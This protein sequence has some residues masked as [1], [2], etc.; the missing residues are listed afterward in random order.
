[1]KTME[2]YATVS[3]VRANNNSQVHLTRST[4]YSMYY[5]YETHYN[6][7]LL[8]TNVTNAISYFTGSCPAFKRIKGTNLIV[9]GFRYA[10]NKLSSFYFLSHFHS[11]HYIGLYQDF[12]CGNIYGTITTLSLVHQNIGV[13]AKYLV[14]L[15]LNEPKLINGALKYTKAV[16]L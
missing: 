11:D 4:I 13:D 12:D 14:P 10:C 2:N 1:M 3:Y 16:S 6:C 5:Y 15:H 9:D 8:L 7:D